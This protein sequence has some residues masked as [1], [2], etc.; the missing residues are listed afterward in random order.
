MADGRSA[1]GLQQQQQQLG[2]GGGGGLRGGQ[3]RA[4]PLALFRASVRKKDSTVQFVATNCHVH[5][6]YHHDDDE[7]KRQSLPHG[8]EGNRL[9]VE[10]EVHCFFSV[11]RCVVLCCAVLCV[12]NIGLTS[13][14]TFPP[15]TLGTM[16]T[17]GG[18]VG[19]THMSQTVSF[20][21]PTAHALN[22]KKGGL[23]RQLL[24]YVEERRGEER[25]GEGNLLCIAV[26]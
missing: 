26:S 15:L 9:I 4:A 10:T 25:R 18:T 14:H 1:N 21:I 5:T 11:L 20:G 2:G 7:E 22:F 24:G 23:H 12:E 6:I 16:G 13:I 19:M 17:V 3:R 8:T